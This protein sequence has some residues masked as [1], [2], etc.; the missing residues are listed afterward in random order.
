MNEKEESINYKILKNKGSQLAILKD[1][2]GKTDIFLTINL[3][4]IKGEIRIAV[5]NDGKM[6]KIVTKEDVML[7][8]D[9]PSLTIFG[10]DGNEL[11][12]KKDTSFDVIMFNFLRWC[13]D[14]GEDRIYEYARRGIPAD[15]R[16][17][18]EDEE[19]KG[20]DS[21]KKSISKAKSNS[22]NNTITNLQELKQ[23]FNKYIATIETSKGYD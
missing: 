4:T 12:V 21:A 15:I 17:I 11:K 1:I 3:P 19:G 2:N 7:L 9:K 13:D 16:G 10:N 5:T 14:K 20:T 22:K 6:L 18:I 23:L 8:P